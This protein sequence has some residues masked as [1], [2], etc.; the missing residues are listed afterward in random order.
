MNKKYMRLLP[1]ILLVLLILVVN[2]VVNNYLISRG[3]ALKDGGIVTL[4][5]VV[6]YVTGALVIDYYHRC[7]KS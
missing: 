1:M 4:V 3:L 5:A 7:D 2:L 6:S